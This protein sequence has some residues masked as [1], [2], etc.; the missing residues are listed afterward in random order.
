MLVSGRLNAERLVEPIAHLNSYDKT[1]LSAAAA[2]SRGYK[3]ESH[4]L[5]QKE[6]HINR[7]KA[8]TPDI[9]T[10]T[11]SSTQMSQWP[12]EVVALESVPVYFF[13]PNRN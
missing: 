8:M 6:I 4:S 1:S 2:I 3:P 5:L 11:T 9:G 10:S 7:I 13:F 12:M